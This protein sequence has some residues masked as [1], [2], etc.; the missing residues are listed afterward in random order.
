MNRAMKETRQ[1]PTSELA[2]VLWDYHRVVGTLATV[3]VIVGLGSYDLRVAHWCAEC[4]IR[5]GT[6]LQFGL[7]ETLEQRLRT[8]DLVAELHAEGCIADGCVALNI[9][10]PY[11]GTQQ[12]LR[13]LRAGT[14]LP[15]YR[16]KPLISSRRSRARRLIICTI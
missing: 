1:L 9:N 2:R 10:S 4:G 6:S 13:M 5:V 15:D 16:T 14:E 12:W 11:P 7:G 3:D 8:L